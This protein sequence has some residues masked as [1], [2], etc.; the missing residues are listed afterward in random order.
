MG[1]RMIASFP[2]IIGRLSPS[3]TTYTTSNPAWS[4]V[5]RQCLPFSSVIGIPKALH[6]AS[7]LLYI[8]DFENLTSKRMERYKLDKTGQ[9]GEKKVT[10]QRTHLQVRQNV[11]E[12]LQALD[13]D[14]QAAIRTLQDIESRIG[15][16]STQLRQID[17]VL[18]EEASYI[19]ALSQR[20]RE[21]MPEEQVL[22]FDLAAAND[23]DRWATSLPAEDLTFTAAFFHSYLCFTRAFVDITTITYRWRLPT[24]YYEAFF[25]HWN[26]FVRD[27]PNITYHPNGHPGMEFQEKVK[28]F[29]RFSLAITHLKDPHI[30]WLVDDSYTSLTGRPSHPKDQGVVP[31]GSTSSNVPNVSAEDDIAKALTLTMLL[32]ALIFASEYATRIQYLF[33]RHPL[34]FGFCG[35]QHP[36]DRFNAYRERQRAVA[37]VASVLA[38]LSK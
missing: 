33:D 27:Q 12:Q 31:S 4:N 25:P 29:I 17:Q 34:F 9:Q 22:R 38:G 11:Q 28:K 35:F 21:V 7:S 20:Y 15:E 26:Q 14:R 13:E 2:I 37:Y 6:T 32:T 19:T 8:F 3:S 36:V 1:S 18:N 5:A 30:G 24:V 10:E 23:L 16:R